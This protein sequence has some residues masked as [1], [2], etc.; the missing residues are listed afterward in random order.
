MVTTGYP[1]KY[2]M[3]GAGVVFTIAGPAAAHSAPRT[4]DSDHDYP[5]ADVVYRPFTAAGVN[6][7][8]VG[9][10]TTCVVAVSG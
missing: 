3:A 9:D 6:Q 10:A 5:V 7:Q 1:L 8:W 4:T 2:D